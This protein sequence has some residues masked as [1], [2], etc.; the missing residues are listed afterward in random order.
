MFRCG[1]KSSVNCGMRMRNIL[2]G[3]CGLLLISACGKDQV[4]EDRA[5]ILD[6]IEDKGLDATEGSEGL[7]Y[8]IDT[9]GNGVSPA[10]TDEVKVDYEGFLLDGTKF[11]SS[12]DRGAPSTFPLSGVIRGWQLGIP[13]FSEGGSGWLLIP[14]ELGYGKNPPSGSVIGKNEVLVFWVKLYEVL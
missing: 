10:V 4:E 11:D 7:F 14:S 13:K 9:V 8:V 3:L 5:L 1:A 12:V 2:L 6:Y